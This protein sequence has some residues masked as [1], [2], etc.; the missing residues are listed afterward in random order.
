MPNP[1]RRNENFYSATVGSAPALVDTQPVRIRS[2]W[3]DGSH[4]E[5][6]SEGVP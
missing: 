3:K 6:V 5:G 4:A 2:R 1:K